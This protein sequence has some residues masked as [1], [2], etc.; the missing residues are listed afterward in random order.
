MAL[1]FQMR[2]NLL[3]I[4]QYQQD[5][6][7]VSIDENPS[8]MTARSECNLIRNPIC[9]PDYNCMTIDASFT[10]MRHVLFFDED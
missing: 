10:K 7:P 8:N 5:D 6:M 9:K 2:C 4:A 3:I 1:G